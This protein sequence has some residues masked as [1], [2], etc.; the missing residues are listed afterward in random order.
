[1]ASIL[2][3]P[4]TSS[5]TGLLSTEEFRISSPCRLSGL[6]PVPVTSAASPAKVTFALS[7][8]TISQFFITEPARL[9]VVLSNVRVLVAAVA[10]PRISVT[11]ALV[12]LPPSSRVAPEISDV[13]LMIMASSPS[14]SSTCPF[15]LEPLFIISVA[16]PAPL[17]TATPDV[18]ETRAPLLRVTTSV[19]PAVPEMLMPAPVPP[20]T[21]PATVTVVGLVPLLVTSMPFVPPLMVPAV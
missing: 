4:V 20:I 19:L 3:S 6:V 12:L 21:E 10:V 15:S 11:L 8:V 9:W 7:S 17:L 16:L 2:T 1:M 18:A 14:P 5:A 13:P